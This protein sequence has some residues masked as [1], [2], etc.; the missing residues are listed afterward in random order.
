MW[1]LYE[2][3]ELTPSTQL[4]GEFAEPEDGADL[5][6]VLREIKAALAD[7]TRRQTAWVEQDAPV[8]KEE[9][10]PPWMLH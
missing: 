10:T 2:A 8:E 5:D 6:A 3:G 9:P 4:T 7:E 1:A